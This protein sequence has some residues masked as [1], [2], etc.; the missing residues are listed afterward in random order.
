ME[1][2]VEN[3]ED[4]DGQ[5][6]K[7]I[8]WKDIT[9]LIDENIET[10]KKCYIKETTDLLNQE[11]T[12]GGLSPY[13]LCIEGQTPIFDETQK[14]NVKANELTADMSALDTEIQTCYHKQRA[15]ELRKLSTAIQTAIDTHNNKLEDYKKKSTALKGTWAKIEALKSSCKQQGIK[16]QVDAFNL[17]NSY[18]SYQQMNSLT[19]EV[20]V[21]IKAPALK[22]DA[23]EDDIDRETKEVE[24]LTAAKNTIDT[25]AS[26][27]E[28]E[29]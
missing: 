18:S 11:M 5:K 8:K 3:A 9:T 4:V 2:K 15:K 28:G 20:T 13:A 29:V 19:R 25:E 10:F 7:I 24:K 22:A 26:K 21:I 17:S 14:L 12:N 23:Y 27:E 16:Y 6:E 1:F